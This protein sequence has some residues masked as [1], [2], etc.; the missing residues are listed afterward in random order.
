MIAYQHIKSGRTY[1]VISTNVINA[2]N[3]NEGTVMVLYK[4]DNSDT[5]YVRE[6]SEFNEKFK[7][8]T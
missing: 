4:G 6:Y 7:I 8:I 5:L 1:Y 3:S 2:T